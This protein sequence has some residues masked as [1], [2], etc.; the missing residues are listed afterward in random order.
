MDRRNV[1]CQEIENC[2][3]IPL[4]ARSISIRKE[5]V[6]TTIQLFYEIPANCYLLVYV[7]IKNIYV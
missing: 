1:C 5:E 7:Q 2:K 3:G 4:F 6:Q